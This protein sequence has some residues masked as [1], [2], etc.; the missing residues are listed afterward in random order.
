[1]LRNIKLFIYYAIGLIAI[2]GC[3]AIALA[4]VLLSIM[5]VPLVIAIV[6]VVIF[7]IDFEEC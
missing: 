1:M 4:M 2:I 3:F 6:A 5:A 7:S